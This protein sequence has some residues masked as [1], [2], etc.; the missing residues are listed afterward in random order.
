MRTRSTCL[1]LALA[2]IVGL[3]LFHVKS[4]VQALHR[5]KSFLMTR[6]GASARPSRHIPSLSSRGT[7]RRAAPTFRLLDRR[8]V[9][10]GAE[11]VRRNPRA[12]SARLRAAVRTEAPPWPREAAA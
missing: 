6:S 10:P 8:A 2:A 1:W 7:A 9:K 3:G 11:E 4:K 12:R 5:V